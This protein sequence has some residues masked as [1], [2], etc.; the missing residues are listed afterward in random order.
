[1]TISKCM[2]LTIFAY[3]YLYIITLLH[4]FF[5]ACQNEIDFE[6]GVRRASVRTREP[7]LSDRA[8]PAAF[9]TLSTSSNRPGAA[10]NHAAS[11]RRHRDAPP[12]HVAAA[13]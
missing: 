3:I 12:I 10:P 4:T 7:K 8:L 11:H 2:E 1:M 6:I 5:R 13:S 9:F